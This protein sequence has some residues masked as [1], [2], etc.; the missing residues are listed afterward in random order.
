MTTRHLTALL[1][2]SA[3]LMPASAQAADLGGN[4]CAD[5]EERI[6]E[7]EVT[8][9]R[10]GNRKVSLE[11]SG[12]VNTSVLFWDDGNETNAY[13]VDNAQDRTRLRF[14]GNAKID[15]DWEA[16]Y[17]LEVGF[18]QARS[19]RVNAGADD[20]N[21]G[22][23]LRHSAWYLQNKQLGRV[24][25][26]Q[27]SQ[28]SDGITQINLA[29]IN[30]VSRSQV[31]DWNADFAI[32]GANASTGVRWRD[33]AVREN[34]GEGNRHNIVRYDSPTFF[35]F[36]ASANWGEDDVWDVGLRYAGEFSGF[37]LAA[38]IA[39]A[40][41]TQ[42]DAGGTA[43]RSVATVTPDA[44]CETLG[45]SVSAL[46]VPTGLFGNFAYGYLQDDRR[47]ASVFTNQIAANRINDRDEFYWFQ[48]GIQQKWIPA[49]KS[50]I[51][52]E[53]YR[54]DFGTS[55]INLVNA[56]VGAAAGGNRVVSSEVDMWGFGFNQSIDA[57]AMDLYVGYRNYEADVTL[58][59]GKAQGL[60]DFQAVLTGAIIRF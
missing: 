43:C 20:T 18:R 48:G 38:G 15:K 13:V 2:T 56:G 57:A 32:R 59:R 8:T 46:H 33:L 1:L 40:Q 47:L 3:I 7:L 6:A 25:V 35:G 39:Y 58:N 10:K 44:S 41:W 5:L 37:K 26:G 45:L 22:I 14:R 24:T 49:G 27:T 42:T 30:H 34:P 17:L 28:V 54:G 52:G 4:C 55:G 9:A 23:D 21:D 53:Y 16:G 29:G 31:F 36:V 19:D 11:V 50:T 60:Q 51:Y 12:W